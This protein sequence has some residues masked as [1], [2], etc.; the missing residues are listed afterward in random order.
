ML[1]IKVQKC[2]LL[3][4][5][6]IVPP[7]TNVWKLSGHAPNDLLTLLNAL[8]LNEAVDQ[9]R[10]MIHIVC[11]NTQKSSIQEDA[12]KKKL[13]FHQNSRYCSVINQFCCHD[14]HC[15][16]GSFRKVIFPLS[17]FLNA[18]SFIIRS[19]C[20]RKKVRNSTERQCQLA[21]NLVISKSS[22]QKIT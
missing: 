1:H 11:L 10:R 3:C 14:G 19:T 18:N 6:F 15:N 12:E 8:L 20:L 2:F 13:D 7:Q 16:F 17:N 4:L 22:E 21:I 9:V 5:I